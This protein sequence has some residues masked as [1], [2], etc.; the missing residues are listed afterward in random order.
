MKDIHEIAGFDPTCEGKALPDGGIGLM[1]PIPAYG[2]RQHR[3]EAK[4]R[5]LS[6]L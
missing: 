6:P 2:V 5:I 3:E 4:G 1:E